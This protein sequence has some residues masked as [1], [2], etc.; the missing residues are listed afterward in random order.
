MLNDLP[1]I[2]AAK[3]KISHEK[4]STI[5]PKFTKRTQYKRFQ[6]PFQKLKFDIHVS[7]N[8]K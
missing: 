2:T 3:D 8:Y 5:N 4:Y 1:K 7:D 6:I